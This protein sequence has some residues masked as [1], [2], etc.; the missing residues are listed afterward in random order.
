M[1]KIG[2]MV[3]SYGMGMLSNKTD[4]IECEFLMNVEMSGGKWHMSG[5]EEEEKV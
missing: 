2:G 1:S 4:L 3:L 5:E